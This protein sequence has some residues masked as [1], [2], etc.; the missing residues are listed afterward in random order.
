MVLF[1]VYYVAVAP[2]V[3]RGQMIDKVH[4]L[5]H[6]HVCTKANSPEAPTLGGK[7]WMGH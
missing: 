6:Y 3:C 7:E 5:V 2:A 4:T 1:L